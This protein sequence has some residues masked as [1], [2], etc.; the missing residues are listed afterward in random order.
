MGGRRRRRRG[1]D[2]LALQARPRV[3]MALQ[4]GE[5]AVPQLVLQVVEGVD[6]EMALQVVEGE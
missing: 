3:K 4:V 2:D 5:G 1:L 6:F